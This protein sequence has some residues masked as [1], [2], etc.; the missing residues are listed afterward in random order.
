M[1]RSGIPGGRGRRAA[2]GTGVD[3]NLG[4]PSDSTRL[5]SDETPGPRLRFDI[6]LCPNPQSPTKNKK[7]QANTYILG[8]SGSSS[9]RSPTKL[10]GHV[11]TGTHDLTAA[12]LPTSYSLVPEPGCLHT[13]TSKPYRSP[14]KHETAREAATELS[15]FSNSNSDKTKDNKNLAKQNPTTKDRS[16]T[17]KPMDGGPAAYPISSSDMNPCLYHDSHVPR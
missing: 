10:N 1:S 8:L 17:A 7:V 16:P 13:M 6:F 3:K 12:R 9:L 14:D 4:K 11:D 5:G 2:E 15:R